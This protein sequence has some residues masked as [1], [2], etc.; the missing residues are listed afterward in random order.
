MALYEFWATT[1]VYGGKWFTSTW[2]SPRGQIET[3]RRFASA[4]NWNFIGGPNG[5][6]WRPTATIETRGRYYEAVAEVDSYMLLEDGDFVL[7]EGGDFV[8]LE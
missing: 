6:Y 8:I 1:L 4:P 5:G 2:P 7:L 3:A